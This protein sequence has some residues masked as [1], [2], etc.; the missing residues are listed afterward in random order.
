MLVYKATKKEFLEDFRKEEII[1]KIIQNYTK[2]ISK[3]N[4]TIMNSWNGSI[5]YLYLLLE[6]E[7]IPDNCGISIEQVIPNIDTKKRIDVMI[8]GKNR[9]KQNVAIIIELKQW[10][11]VKQPADKIGYI[12]L[13]DRKEKILRTHPS[14][15]VHSY[16][17]F[18][19]TYNNAFITNNIQTYSCAFLHNYELNNNDVLLDEKYNDFINKSPLFF[20]GDMEKLRSYINDKICE[21][22]NC[23]I[24][25][26]IENSYQSITRLLTP[27]TVDIIKSP[28]VVTLIDEQ[29]IVC[30][31]ALEMAK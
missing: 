18:F 9:D 31:K 12:V 16:L 20:R 23:K 30:E 5:P 17:H 13:S 1:G 25:D 10:S 22:D 8:T 24:I 7:S 21:G 19:K 29:E 11:K 27:R 4:Y 28:E 3:P 6:D 14:F 26:V 2:N 15:Q